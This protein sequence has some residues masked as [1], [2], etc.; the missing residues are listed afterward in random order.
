MKIEDNENLQEEDKQVTEEIVD[1][2]NRDK[3]YL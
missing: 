2:I 3:Q 1:F